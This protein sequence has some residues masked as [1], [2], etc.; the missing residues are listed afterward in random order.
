[1]SKTIIANYGAGSLGKS[2]SIKA[3]FEK[4]KKTYKHSITDFI[5]GGD[6]RAIIHLTDHDIKIGL[7]SQGDP[8]SRMEAS[9]NLFV[10]KSCDIIISACRTKGDT[11]NKIYDVRNTNGYE[12]IWAQ[13]IISE[14]KK[15]DVDLINDI[16]STSILEIIDN[17][18]S[19]KL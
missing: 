9:M 2:S 18:L 13:N 5:D 8:N 6:V 7:E 14:S 4:I 10:A 15:H 1:M 17:L 3:V 11:I 19:G 16:Y 12:I